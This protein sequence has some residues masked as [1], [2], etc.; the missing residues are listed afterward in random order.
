MLLD[1]HFGNEVRN[2]AISITQRGFI[3]D[4]YKVNLVGQWGKILVMAMGFVD[5]FQRGIHIFM[6]FKR[7]YKKILNQ[8]LFYE[9]RND[10]TNISYVRIMKN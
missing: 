8:S 2:G 5:Q 6:H 10:I 9:N 1:S 7:F 4:C 3:N